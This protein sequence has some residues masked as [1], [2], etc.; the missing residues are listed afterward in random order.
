MLHQSLDTRKRQT[1]TRQVVIR[2]IGHD[3]RLAGGGNFRTYAK[4]FCDVC[5]FSSR[6]LPSRA[7]HGQ[8]HALKA[9]S[10]A[11]SV[12]VVFSY[13]QAKVLTIQKL[14]STG[15]LYLA[16]LSAVARSPTRGQAHHQSRIH[17]A[18]ECKCRR[19]LPL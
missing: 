14:G 17:P 7:P 18:R 9:V 19:R 3:P 4:S 8:Q 11:R 10:A 13:K 6:R 12:T 2:N 16:M 5:D 15:A 1:R